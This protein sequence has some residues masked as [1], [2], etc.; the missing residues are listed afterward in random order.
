MSTSKYISI[1]YAGKFQTYSYFINMA[2]KFNGIRSLLGDV[3][4]IYFPILECLLERLRG[5]WETIIKGKTTCVRKNHATH[6][7]LLLIYLYKLYSVYISHY[8]KKN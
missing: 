4:E 2:R 6:V 1:I 8:K 7:G 5:D 3:P